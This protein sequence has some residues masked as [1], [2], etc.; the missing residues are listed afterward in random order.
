M[1]NERALEFAAQSRCVV[2]AAAGCGKT[3]LIAQA[4]AASNHSRQLILTHTHAGVR[5][6][7]DRLQRR[8]IDPGTYSVDTISG[9]SLR[10]ACSFP[11][12][13]R[14]RITEPGTTAD[15]TQIYEAAQEALRHRHVRSV[16]SHSYSGLFVDEYQDC[17][18]KQHELIKLL[19]ELLPTRIVGD[20]LQGIFDFSPNEDPIVDWP[21]DVYPFFRRLA[22]LQTP[23]RWQQ[24][25]DALGRWLTAV[26]MQLL[27]GEAFTLAPG[28]PVRFVELTDPRFSQA[29]LIRTCWTL[30]QNS[31]DSI[32]II[33]KWPGQAHATSKML[34]GHFRS[35]EEVECKDLLKWCERLEASSGIERATLL[36]EFAL[37]CTTKKPHCLDELIKLLRSGQLPG[38]RKLKNYPLL[39]D[40]VGRVVRLGD[41]SSLSGMLQVIENIPEVTLHRRELFREMQRVMR[42]HSELSGD[43]LRS[44]AWKIRDR[45]RRVGRV[46]DPRVV[47]R[48]TLIKG[49]EFDHAI[50]VDVDD[51]QDARN[52]YVA[53][54]RGAKSL[55]VMSSSRTVQR[56]AP[57][58]L[59][60]AMNQVLIQDALTMASLHFPGTAAKRS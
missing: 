51:F 36:L 39:K 34:S 33:R 46:V 44:T 8:R 13:S 5:A 58:L 20:P 49:L 3:E 14:C 2:V 48:T 38:D 42:N 22:D 9:F 17:T 45:A 16:L 54:T 56:P 15:W 19:A 52:L 27:S 60:Q 59:P 47:S 6:L 32:A 12:L 1:P 7:K 21:R 10:Y 37:E 4:V 31:R 35:M 55:T 26:R 40:A 11:S 41:V 43:S 25:N 24:Q 23:Y 28:G 29:A 30:P 50:I 57:D 18:V 53:L